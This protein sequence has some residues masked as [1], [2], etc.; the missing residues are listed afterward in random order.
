MI[1]QCAW[2]LLLMGETPPLSDKAVTHG[3][4]KACEKKLMEETAAVH[5]KVCVK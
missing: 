3:I 5:K 4:C 2:C 1:R